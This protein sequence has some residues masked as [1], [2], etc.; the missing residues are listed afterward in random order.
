M[1]TGSRAFRSIARLPVSGV[2]QTGSLQWLNPDAFASVVDPSTGA[3]AGGD[4]PA[5]CQ[6]GNSGRNNYRGPHF[7]YSEVYVTKKIPITEHV[8]FRFDTQFFNVFNHP[9]FALPSNQAGTPGEAGDADRLWRADQHHLSAHR[10]AGRGTRRRQFA[11]HD[12]V[13][14]KDRILI[15]YHTRPV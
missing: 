15:A 1:R 11:A 2:T 7:T 8:T 13:P 6:F 3:C 9:N 12:R 10:T 4:S 5:N 14:G